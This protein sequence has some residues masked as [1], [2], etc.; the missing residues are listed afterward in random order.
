MTL[1]Q[2]K[3]LQGVNTVFQI[4]LRTENIRILYIYTIFVTFSVRSYIWNTVL[5][6]TLH[7]IGKNLIGRK[8]NTKENK[9]NKENFSLQQNLW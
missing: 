5:S 7:E 8:T 6:D 4:Y 3:K 1:L 9:G 2:L